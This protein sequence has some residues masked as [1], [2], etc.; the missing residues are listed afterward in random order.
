VDTK[1]PA[2]WVENKHYERESKL[3]VGALV[4]ISRSDGSIRFGELKAQRATCVCG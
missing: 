1:I 3:Q 2:G 4:G